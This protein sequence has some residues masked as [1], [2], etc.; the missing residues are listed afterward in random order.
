MSR[1]ST[2]APKIKVEELPRDQYDTFTSMAKELAEIMEKISLFKGTMDDIRSRCE[3]EIGVSRSDLNKM[4]K[5][6][7]EQEKMEEALD[8]LQNQ[9]EMAERLNL[10]RD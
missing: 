5:W 10:I 1:P 6:R 3:E 8:K 9:R 4:A 2:K 7:V